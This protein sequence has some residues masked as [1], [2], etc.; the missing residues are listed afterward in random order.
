MGKFLFLTKNNKASIL[1]VTVI[2]MFIM[3][4]IAY[5]CIKMFLV[6][7]VIITQDQIKARVTYAAAGIAQKQVMRLQAAINAKINQD[8]NVEITADTA[9]DATGIKNLKKNGTNY[10]FLFSDV[11]NQTA[12]QDPDIVSGQDFF[13][14]KGIN[15][16]S[17]IYTDAMLENVIMFP[18]IKSLG[19]T[20]GIPSTALPTAVRKDGGV[21]FYKTKGVTVTEEDLKYN[22]YMEVNSTAYPFNNNDSN[23]PR[24][25]K[26]KELGGDSWQDLGEEYFIV[27]APS[28]DVGSR[29]ATY[30]DP[31]FYAGPLSFYPTKDFIEQ[32][33]I[34]KNV[35]TN[36]VIKTARHR[37]K[38]LFK[39]VR[40][41]YCITIN[42]ESQAISNRIPKITSEIKIFFDL[43]MPKLYIGFYSSA[44]GEYYQYSWRYSYG[45]YTFWST[46]P[47]DNLQGAIFIPDLS[48]KINNIKFH[49][50]K[51][52]VVS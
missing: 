16:A 37:V 35:P 13:T 25:I 11:L 4:I 26:N 17:S 43:F 40:Q 29:N 48:K 50:Q 39:N 49:I 31:V 1:P 51:W 30:T 27:N 7:N 6:Q 9:F 19:S 5:A 36:N 38:Y 28:G 23:D 8:P 33:I 2:A 34:S 3:M 24:V 12:D 46:G 22:D 47:L 21:S 44:N 14:A 10:N 45:W 18:R 32:L 15:G 20:I 42:A 52:E 41:T